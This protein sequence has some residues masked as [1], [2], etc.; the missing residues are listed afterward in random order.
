[1][2][3]ANK[4]RGIYSLRMRNEHDRSHISASTEC[5]IDAVSLLST[6]LINTD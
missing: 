1:L 5:V 2:Q 4:S 3:S 6:D